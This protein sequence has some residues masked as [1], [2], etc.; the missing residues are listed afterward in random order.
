MHLMRAP[1]QKILTNPISEVWI[2]TKFDYLPEMPEMPDNN[3]PTEQGEASLT[4]PRVHSY[5]VLLEELEEKQQ[6]LPLVLV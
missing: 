4:R 6:K 3:A 1:V 2:E 5:D